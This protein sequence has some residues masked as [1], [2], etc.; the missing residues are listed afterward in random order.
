M[1][2][3]AKFVTRQILLALVCISELQASTSQI[4]KQIW[5]EFYKYRF[6]SD[7]IAEKEVDSKWIAGVGLV[8]FFG[9]EFN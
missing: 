7:R 5:F 1:N 3:W 8:P 2:A 4:R 6:L 9:L